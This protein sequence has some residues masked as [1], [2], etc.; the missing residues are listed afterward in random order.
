MKVISFSLIELLV[1]V[2]IIAVLAAVALPVYKQ[3]KYR[4]NVEKAYLILNSIRDLLVA[5]YQKNGV[6]P[7][8]ISYGGGTLTVNTLNG[9]STGALANVLWAPHMWG[10]NMWNYG[11]V[12]FMY[13]EVLGLDGY[14]H[15]INNGTTMTA[16]NPGSTLA[17]IYSVT[18][19]AQNGQTIYS[20]C[21]MYNYDD[22]ESVPLELQPGSCK[23]QSLSGAYTGGSSPAIGGGC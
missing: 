13:G 16:Y 4:A 12:I 15:K 2:A 6:F 21:G 10:P 9:L 22:G 17:N 7:S 1:V 8:T 14:T 18:E 3:Y 23:C 11:D 20:W 5:S 19:M